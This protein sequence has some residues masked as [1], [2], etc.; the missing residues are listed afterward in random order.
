MKF[1]PF[2]LPAGLLIAAVRVIEQND[3]PGLTI[4]LVNCRNDAGRAILEL[5]RGTD[6]AEE[7]T[8]T[9]IMNQDYDEIIRGK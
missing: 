2:S 8:F 4:R 7:I 3:T 6:A 1:I 5:S 9:V